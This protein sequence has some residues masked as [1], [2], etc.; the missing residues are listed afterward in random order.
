[1]ATI[2]PCAG[3]SVPVLVWRITPPDEAA[4]DRYEGFPYLYR[5]ENVKVK[6]GGKTITAMV[7]I[8][9]EGRPLNQPGAY[10]FGTILEGYITAGIDTETLIKATEDSLKVQ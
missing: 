10:Y 3:R 7:Y 2:E 9:N 1:V 6:M 8:M 5:K 4:L